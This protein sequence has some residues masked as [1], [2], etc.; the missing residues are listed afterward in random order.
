MQVNCKVGLTR[1]FTV[2]WTVWLL[3]VLFFVYSFGHIIGL[4]TAL[5]VVGLWGI[6]VPGVLV[7]SLCWLFA[8]FAG[9][10]AG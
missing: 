6:V 3:L 7:L 8:G 10:K 1:L 2:T 4:V 5:E 9:G